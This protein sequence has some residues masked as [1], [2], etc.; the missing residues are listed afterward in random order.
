MEST[1][2]SL[3]RNAG[4]AAAGSMLFQP[5]ASGA[6]ATQP[7]G[8]APATKGTDGAGL[9]SQAWCMLR[10][11]QGDSL[12][13]RRENRILDLGKAGK[14]LKV[15]VPA[16]TDEL[17]EGKAIAGL[18]KV[19]VAPASSV[20]AALVPVEEAR[21]GPCITR[22]Q[23]IIMLGFNYRKHALET[24]TPFPKAPVLFNKYNNA[25]LGHEGTIKLPT[26]VA[27]KFDYEVEL[28]VI[29]GRIA[30]DVSEG[31]ALGHVFGYATG[32]DFSARDLQLRDG[33]GA[34]QFMIGKTSDGFMPIGPWLVGADLVGDPQKLK[35]ETRVNGE[36][37]QSSNT[38]DMIFSCAQIIA[39]ASSIFTL[40]PG[41]VI[42]TGTPEG[43]ILGKPEGQ[44]VWL[45]A[46]DRIECSVEKCGE[47]RFS[48]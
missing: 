28:Q 14:A 35:V 2:R 31:E 32:N 5:A 18:Q 41:D 34:S 40:F 10:T 15:T 25:L 45:K 48:L 23:K 26:K 36:T 33:R 30:R 3:L 44:Q 1:R 39:Y 21:F 11:P 20:K 4:V 19:L 43:V 12:G 27:K 42:S 17:L 16:S 13:L 6:Q 37:R 38:D 22:P 9:R 47:L 24:N 8:P 7:A 29:M 46:G